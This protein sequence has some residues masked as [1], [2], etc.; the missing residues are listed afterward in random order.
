MFHV[1]HINPLGLRGCAFRTQ[2]LTNSLYV[3]ER[4]RRRKVAV[5]A[6]A[7]FSH[8]GQIQPLTRT[9]H[10]RE[11]APALAPRLQLPTGDDQSR[12]C[13]VVLIFVGIKSKEKRLA[14]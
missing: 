14:A 12:V 6:V 2:P 1:S 4:S 10:Y 9:G 3:L 13:A 5:F 7:H 11:R 8:P